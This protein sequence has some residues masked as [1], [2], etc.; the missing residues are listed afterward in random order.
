MQGFSAVVIV[1]SFGSFQLL[2]C[3]VI[4]RGIRSR[5]YGRSK[6]RS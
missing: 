6:V 5:V 4:V 3:V 2:L 1:A